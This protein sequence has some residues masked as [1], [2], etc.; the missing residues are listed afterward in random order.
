MPALEKLDAGVATDDWSPNTGAAILSAIEAIGGTSLVWTRPDEFTPSADLSVFLQSPETE[1]FAVAVRLQASST[2]EGS[3]FGMLSASLY[4]AS[5]ELFAE[6]ANV[7]LN[8][9]STAFLLQMT[10]TGLN[11]VDLSGQWTL[12]VTCEHG[13]VPGEITLDFLEVEVDASG[14]GGQSAAGAAMLMMMC[15]V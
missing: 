5:D 2:E 8:E 14:P 4:D 7:E 9:S 12:V 1:P 3:E 13:F 10:L 6:V 11:P 15:G